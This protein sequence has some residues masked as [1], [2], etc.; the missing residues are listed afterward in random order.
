[1]SHFKALAY[2]LFV[3][4]VGC[5]AAAHTAK[6]PTTGNTNPSTNLNQRSDSDN[7]EA[8]RC[9]V[10][11]VSG[12]TLDE[13]FGPGTA[14][15]T[16]CLEKDEVKVVYGI[17]KTCA[18]EACTRAYALGNIQ[19][20][21]KDYEI[22]H[23][24]S[25]GSDYKIIAVVYSGG[26]QLVVSNNAAVPFKEENPFQTQVEELMAQGVEFYF[27]QNAARSNGVVTANLIPG[28]KFATA[29]VTAIADFQKMGYSYVSP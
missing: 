29:G 10:G 28:I 19:N 13:E 18:N 6:R 16:R 26:Y 2:L 27:C 11:L 20:A 15:I 17:N 25:V 5:E 9:P 21:I 12:K 7:N 8:A 1:M 4:L 14:E 22:T 24:M 3:F 23:G